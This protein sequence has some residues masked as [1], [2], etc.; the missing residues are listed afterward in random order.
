MND[1]RQLVTIQV[2]VRWWLRYYLYAVVLVSVLTDLDP[3]WRK[4]ESWIRR[5]LVL[6]QVRVRAV[7][8]A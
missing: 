1:A 5:G 2:S 3:D 6:K 8:A 7:V 4:V